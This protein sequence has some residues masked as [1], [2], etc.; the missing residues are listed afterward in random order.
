MARSEYSSVERGIGKRKW[1]GADFMMIKMK[2]YPASVKR[3]AAYSR[4]KAR[5]A[6]ATD[7]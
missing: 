1:A 5:R 4:F 6:N 7:L 3:L 2:Q